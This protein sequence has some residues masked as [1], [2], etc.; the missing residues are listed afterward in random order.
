MTVGFDLGEKIMGLIQPGRGRSRRPA[1]EMIEIVD[2]LPHLRGDDLADGT[3]VLARL[4]KTGN[5]G[6]RIIPIEGQETENILLGGLA[7]LL[8]EPLVVAGNGDHRLPLLMG[9]HFQIE[10]EVKID[11]DKTGN[12]LGPF[13][14]TGHPVN[15]I[16]DTAQH[17]C[18]SSFFP[19]ITG[20]HPGVLTAAPPWEE[21]TTREPF[22]RATRVKP[23]GRT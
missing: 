6:V 11:V 2:L 19:T 10:H 18:F 15:M 4:V 3:G 21:L 23:P 16:S 13:D 12:I 5:D 14:I 8:L 22:F 7:V 9:I 1:D 20:H 17:F